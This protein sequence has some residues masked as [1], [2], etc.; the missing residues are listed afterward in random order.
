MGT[1]NNYLFHGLWPYGDEAVAAITIATTI[2]DLAVVLFQGT[3][4]G[5][6]SHTGEMSWEPEN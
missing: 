1:G 6:S 3:Q 5:N 2:Q 4:R